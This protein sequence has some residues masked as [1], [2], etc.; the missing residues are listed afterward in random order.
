LIFIE[1]R[2][3]LLAAPGL[4][5]DH[6]AGVVITDDGQ[7][8]V[9]VAVAD[10]IDTDPIQRLQPARVEQLGHSTVDDRGDGFPAAAHQG[11]H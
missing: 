6:G 2:Q 4:D 9:R 3:G 11:G 8:A 10:L 7:I 5:V 1:I